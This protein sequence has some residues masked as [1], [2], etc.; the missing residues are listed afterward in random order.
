[1]SFDQSARAEGTMTIRR[2]YPSR[3]NPTTPAATHSTSVDGSGAGCG[4][5]G[6]LTYPLTS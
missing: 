3:A 4:S 5:G 2:R 6:T 1:M